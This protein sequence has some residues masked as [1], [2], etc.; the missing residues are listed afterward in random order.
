MPYEEKEDVGGPGSKN[1]APCV[2]KA[3]KDI[4]T[5]NFLKSQRHGKQIA[6]KSNK[7]GKKR[8]G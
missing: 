6:K 4:K 1:N 2:R 7:L 5:R 8:S 3:E